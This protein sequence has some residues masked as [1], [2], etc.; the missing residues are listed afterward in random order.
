MSDVFAV[1]PGDL[2]AHGGHIESVADGVQGA[3]QAAQTVQAGSAAYGK[4]CVFVPVMLGALHD[5]LVEGITDSATALRDT[6][7]KLRATASEY[8]GTD[9][10]SA[11][12][13]GRIGDGL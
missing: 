6:G 4:L 1:R 7:A 5:V 9:Q 10:A 8:D 3:A 12:A 11:D 13:F 2:L